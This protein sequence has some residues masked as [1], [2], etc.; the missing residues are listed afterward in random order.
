MTSAVAPVDALPA[1]PGVVA[2]GA[3]VASVAVPDVLSASL[4]LAQAPRPSASAAAS[5]VIAGF[6]G[7]SPRGERR[8]YARPPND[9]VEPRRSRFT[10]FRTRARP[11]PPP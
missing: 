2:A 9:A 3:D 11:G 6:M 4:S 10:A 8:T 5:S 7:G 1:S